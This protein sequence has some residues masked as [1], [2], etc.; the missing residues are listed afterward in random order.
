MLGCS[1]G[2]ELGCTEVVGWVDRKRAWVRVRDRERG[3]VSGVVGEKL[4]LMAG[5]SVEPME[6]SMAVYLAAHSAVCSVGWMVAMWAAHSA[7]C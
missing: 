7:V 3:G 5:K 2:L 6:A 4:H 1:L